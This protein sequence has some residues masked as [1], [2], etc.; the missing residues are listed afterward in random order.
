MLIKLLCLAVSIIL[1]I[2][3]I[4]GLCKT[5]N[6][7]FSLH[8]NYW[9]IV[10]FSTISSVYDI[11]MFV[12][13]ART[14]PPGDYG[15]GIEIL[16][17]IGVLLIYAPACIVTGWKLKCRMKLYDE[18][19]RDITTMNSLNKSIVFKVAFIMIV[20]IWLVEVK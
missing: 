12:V 13:V 6:A 16:A 5:P 15:T 3:G 10:F 8:Q 17:V 14:I 9:R 4:V 2:V 7:R 1:G 19:E 11:I 18:T 20:T